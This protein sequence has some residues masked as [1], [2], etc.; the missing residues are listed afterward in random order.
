MRNLK[1]EINPAILR[2]YFSYDPKTGEL[3]WKKLDH[4]VR[5]AKVGDI[6]GCTVSEED[7]RVTVGFKKKLIRAHII[8]W[9]YMTGEWPTHRIDHKNR[10]PSDNRWENLRVATQS[11]NM[12]NITRPTKAN[13]SGYRGVHFVKRLSRWSPWCAKIKADGISYTLGHFK[14]K[15]EAYEAYKKASKKLRKSFSPYV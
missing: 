1:K 7:G 12:A 8:I 6:A 10:N 3:R 14:T 2:E 13:K 9:A 5:N 11:Q 15:E 4:L